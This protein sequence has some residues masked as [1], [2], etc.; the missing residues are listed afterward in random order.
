[1]QQLSRLSIALGAV[2]IG[3][4]LLLLVWLISRSLRIR[5]SRRS[6]TDLV[7]VGC[8]PEFVLACEEMHH[9]EA[10]RIA[11]SLNGVQWPNSG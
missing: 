7:L 9:R 2:L 6:T 4:D 11:D 10:K 1:M 8:A 5:A 3:L